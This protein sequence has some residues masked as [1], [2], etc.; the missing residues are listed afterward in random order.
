MFDEKKAVLS[1]VAKKPVELLNTAFCNDSLLEFFKA[2][3]ALKNTNAKVS[4]PES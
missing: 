1:L 4:S 3:N 2:R